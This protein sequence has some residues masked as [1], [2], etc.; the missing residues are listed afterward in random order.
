MVALR[1]AVVV[2]FSLSAPVG[3]LMVAPL[4]LERPFET[5]GPTY[6][7]YERHE[8]R[9]LSQL[10]LAGKRLFRLSCADCHGPSAQGT[11]R[12]VNLMAKAYHRDRFGKREF[13][14]AV[15]GDGRTA[16]IYGHSFT[17]FSFNNVERLERYIRELQKPL[18]FR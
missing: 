17:E 18:S 13:H 1:T 9:K 6:D 11:Q 10:G 5:V 12:G 7:V 3:G 4:V 16:A 2:S 15:R 14:E 8:D